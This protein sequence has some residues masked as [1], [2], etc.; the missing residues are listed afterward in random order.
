MIILGLIVFYVI[1]IFVI[2]SVLYLHPYWLSYFVF[3]PFIKIPTSYEPIMFNLPATKYL[4]SN[5]RIS[6]WDFANDSN[7]LI[8]YIHGIY[9]D[10]TY[11]T[12]REL[13]IKLYNLNYHV[14]SYDSNGYG[15]SVNH[16]LS[17]DG[18]VNSFITLYIYMKY[19]YNKEIIVWAHSLGT[20]IALKGLDRLNELNHYVNYCILE[21]PFYDFV[22]AF[23]KY[24]LINY[25]I[26]GKNLIK[27]KLENIKISFLNYYYINK[28]NTKILLFHAKDDA[29]IPYY[30]SVRLAFEC[31]HCKLILF[32]KGGHSYLY[33]NSEVYDYFNKFVSGNLEF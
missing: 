26:Y 12:R 30:N 22:T 24:P 13:C 20:G 10:R 4:I 23:D 31:Q 1:I 2:C 33:K 15:D 29:T 8:I 25:F 28:T 16:N 14:I 27:K 19:K 5:G 6:I 11:V 21:S 3:G 7:K 17:E 9:S 18:L 32:N